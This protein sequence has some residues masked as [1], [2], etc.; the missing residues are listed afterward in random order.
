MTISHALSMA[1]RKA[2]ADR[3]LAMIRD[4]KKLWQITKEMKLNERHVIQVLD[5]FRLIGVDTS[6]V[7]QEAML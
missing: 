4:G 2:K 3:V 6:P 7:K 5:A 1:T